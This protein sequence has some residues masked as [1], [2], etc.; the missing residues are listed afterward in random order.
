MLKHRDITGGS[1]PLTRGKLGVDALNTLDERLIPAHAGKT[2]H[3]VKETPAHRVHPR[4]RGGKRIKHL[5]EAVPGGLIPAH[6]GKT[7]AIAWQ[8]S[9]ARVHPHARGENANTYPRFDIDA[10]SS[11]LTQGKPSAVKQHELGA[12]L[13][14][15]HAGKMATRS[16]PPS[17]PTAHPRSRGEK[18]HLVTVDEAWAGSSPPTGEN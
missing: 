14:P 2:T 12:G 5:L 8:V 10:G 11:P 16:R 3:S 17:N 18:L 4:S 6:A 15:T 1:S 13:I 7:A 9:T